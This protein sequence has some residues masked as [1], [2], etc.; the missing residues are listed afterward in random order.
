MAV[1][2]VTD[3]RFQAVEETAIRESRTREEIVDEAIDLYVRRK[4][5]ARLRAVG[6]E[7]VEA[8]ITEEDVN[9]AFRE[10]REEERRKRA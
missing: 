8:G 10:V 9:E 1:L 2:T 6:Q 7:M 4:A 5:W 3:A